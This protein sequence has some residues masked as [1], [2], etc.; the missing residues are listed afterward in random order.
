MFHDDWHFSIVHVGVVCPN[1]LGFPV[2]PLEEL[3]TVVVLQAELQVSDQSGLE[4]CCFASP[5]GFSVAKLVGIQ[6][7]I[8]EECSFLL[9]GRNTG[10]IL[11]SL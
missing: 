1:E 2:K 4:M 9:E 8:Q 7:L 11:L 10:T 5:R 6:F 3:S